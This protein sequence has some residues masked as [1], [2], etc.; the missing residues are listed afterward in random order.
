M[1]AAGPA[2]AQGHPLPAAPSPFH[3]R[4]E[5]ADAAALVRVDEVEAGRLH[6]ERLALLRGATPERFAIKRAPSHPPALGAGDRAVVL[7]RGARAPYVLAEP[8]QDAIRLADSKAAQRWREALAALLAAGTD[9][10]ARLR[11]YVDWIDGGP[12]TLAEAGLVGALAVLGDAP[13]LAGPFGVERARAAVDPARGDDARRISALLAAGT[14]QGA[15]VLV[16][17]VARDVDAVPAV[18]LV[19]LQAG[20]RAG[21]PGLAAAFGRAAAH[22]DPEVRLAALQAARAVAPRAPEAVGDAL[23]RLAA[24][25]PEEGVRRRAA[26]L[27]RSLSAEDGSSATPRTHPALAP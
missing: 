20:A 6:V 26:R 3:E 19:A 15:A 12:P 18:V 21:A 17:A 16:D 27:A 4:L 2:R 13:E 23:A 24:D 8:D 22:D 10:P 14:P 5:R 7:L 9:P 1:L 25:D 11:T